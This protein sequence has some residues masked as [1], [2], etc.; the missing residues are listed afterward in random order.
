MKAD[1][2]LSRRTALK[3]AVGIAAAAGVP[4]S[5]LT[6][7]SREADTSATNEKNA[8][9]K[10]PTYVPFS[11]VKPDLAG[12]KQGAMPT[13]FK[14]PANPAH[15]TE[16]IP[17]EG[18]TVSAM[19]IIYSSLPPS[20]GSNK[21]WQEL[22]K[23]LGVEL[24]FNMVNSTDYP[25]KL[26][27]QVAGGDLPDIVNFFGGV[28]SMPQLL[29][30]KFQDLT[31]FL[32]GDAIKEYPCLAAL[33]A[34]CWKYMLYN[35]GIYG[36]PIPRSPV[37]SI[38]LTRD[39]I[40]KAKGLN[41]NPANFQEFRELCKGLTDEDASKWAAGSTDGLLQYVRSMLGIPNGWIRENG[42]F[43]N[44][45]ETDTMH[46]ALSA[47]RTLVKDGSVHPDAFSADTAKNK[48]WM[49]AG[50]IAMN[51]DGYKGWSTD[52]LAGLPDRLHQLG[53]LHTP[54]FDGGKGTHQEGNSTFAVVSLKKADKKRIKELLRICN[55]LAAPF[56]SEECLFRKYGLKGQDYSVKAG[57]PVLT[58]VGVSE[59]SLPTKYI[60]DCTD[61]IYE[62]GNEAL[63]KKEH[64]F[65][66]KEAEL[67][68][69]NPSAALYSDANSRKGPEYE[70]E[71]TKLRAQ[72][73]Q[74]RKSLSDWDDLVGKWKDDIGDTI[75]KDYEKAY[76]ELH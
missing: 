47:V 57:E 61:F 13:F 38:M 74:G 22:N 31:E 15:A 50:T 32:S 56:G 55:W 16:G 26:A 36:I 69:P 76:G 71:F 2:E 60:T 9:V 59:T 72:I 18:G 23:R 3:S 64:E 6:G 25:D 66:V 68:I 37:G 1:F 63:A 30:A 44:V 20:T 35:G 41:H 34:D 11:K 7:C 70:D 58:D 19:T 43:V 62:P 49:F 48:N 40:I 17:G 27:T 29:K 14:Y 46:Q 33:P 39:D 12:T 75:R 67:I 73:F 45:Y 8:K 52:V 51:N 24:K 53:A 28:P 54:G 65:F 42:K 5:V 21:Y 10:L 4:L